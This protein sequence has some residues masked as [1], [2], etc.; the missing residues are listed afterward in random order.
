LDSETIDR[1]RRRLRRALRLAGWLLFAAG[2]ASAQTATPPIE[3]P[4]PW[5]LA[6]SGVWYSGT[7]PYHLVG[8]VSGDVHFESAGGWGARLSHD[9][10][11]WFD[12]GVAWTH[13]V[14]DLRLSGSDSPTLGSRQ[15]NTLEGGGDFHW[16]H[17]PLRLS[18]LTGIG[19]AGTGT[20]KGSINLT[21]S[22]GAGASF[23]LDRHLALSL[24]ERWRATY[25]NLG[26]FDL[27]AYCDATGCY[28]YRRKFYEN[29]EAAG[30]LTIVF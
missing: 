2:R 20:G 3:S 25:G 18:F 11:P 19:G 22:V 5:R 4:L 14:T 12:V 17:G 29:T 8:A 15:I 26:P 27:Y 7:T 28:A 1:S 23:S 16:V 10:L 21:A 9:V 6:I 13:V 24:T 30:G